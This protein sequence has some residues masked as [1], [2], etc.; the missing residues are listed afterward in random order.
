MNMVI[1]GIEYDTEKAIEIASWDNN[2]MP[3]DFEARAETLYATVKGAYFRTSLGFNSS[4]N[5]R[6][7]IFTPMTDKEALA[8]CEEHGCIDEAKKHFSHMITEA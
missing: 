4:G 1:D 3:S 6:T 7:S 5:G 8:W 2:R